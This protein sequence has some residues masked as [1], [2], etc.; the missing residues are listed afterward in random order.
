MTGEPE[1]GGENGDADDRI[2]QENEG[3]GPV[4]PAKTPVAGAPGRFEGRGEEEVGEEE[5][6]GGGPDRHVGGQG[7]PKHGAGCQERD[8]GTNPEEVAPWSKESTGSARPVAG[9]QGECSA[10]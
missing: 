6:E 2:Q 8:Q 4:R 1:E 5:E 3:P 10:Q 7:Q 9:C